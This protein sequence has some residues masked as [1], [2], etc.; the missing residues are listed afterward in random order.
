[1]YV[2]IKFLKACFAKNNLN[3]YHYINEIDAYNNNARYV[4][5]RDYLRNGGT[6]FL[7]TPQPQHRQQTLIEYMRYNDFNAIINSRFDDRTTYDELPDNDIHTT[8]LAFDSFH[9]L[10]HISRYRNNNARIIPSSMIASRPFRL[11]TL[12]SIGYG[13]MFMYH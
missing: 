11:A 6:K 4:W 2:N 5:V 1:L 10:L 13:P 7:A 9:D 12:G 3:A 8:G